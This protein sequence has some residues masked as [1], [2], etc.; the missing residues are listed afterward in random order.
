[1]SSSNNQQDEFVKFLIAAQRGDNAAQSKLDEF[2]KKNPRGYLQFLAKI[3]AD[4]TK[5]DTARFTA[6]ISWKNLFDIKDSSELREKR[7]KQWLSL[8][9]DFRQALKTCALRGLGSPSK[10]V[11]RAAAQVIGKVA[12]IELPAQQWPELVRGLLSQVKAAD[13]PAHLKIASLNCIEYICEGIP[14]LEPSSLNDILNALTQGMKKEIGNF[15]INFAAASA[16]DKCLELLDEP[17][18]REKD[19]NYIMKVVCDAVAID[20]QSVNEQALRI[21]GRMALL[22][23]QHFPRYIAH[24]MKITKAILPNAS[25]TVAQQALEFWCTIC[26]VEYD[27][28]CAIDAGSDDTCHNFIKSCSGDL[29]ALTLPLLVQEEFSDSDDFDLPAA[30]VLLL[31][32]ISATV[33]DA[34]IDPVWAWVKSHLRDGSPFNR[35]AASAAFGAITEGP[36]TDALA[37]PINQILPMFV[38]MLE[39]DSS[40][41]V[42]ETVAWALARVCEFHPFVVCDSNDKLGKILFS[43]CKGLNDTPEVATFCCSAIHNIAIANQD[44][45]KSSSCLD[46]YF[47]NVI[48]SLL[49][50][51]ERKNLEGTDLINSAY[52]AISLLIQNSSDETLPAV[53]ILCENFLTRLAKSFSINVVSKSD[54]EL[55]TQLQGHICAVILC[56]IQKLDSDIKP[57]ARTMMNHFLQIFK[58]SG[59]SPYVHEDALMAVGS[60]ANSLQQDFLPFVEEVTPF[61]CKGLGAIQHYAVCIASV[62]AVSDI[63][64]AIGPHFSRLPYPKIMT[65]LVNAIK[66]TSLHRS[67]KPHILAAFGDIA[68]ALSDKFQKFFPTVVNIL[69]WASKS[70]RKDDDE[71]YNAYIDALREGIL[72]GFTGI[73]HGLK[74]CHQAE[75]F[76][77]F[78]PELAAFLVSSWEDPEHSPSIE[79]SI[80]G[81]IGDVAS[82]MGRSSAQYIKTS[83]IHAIINKAKRSDD[84]SLREM[85][86]WAQQQIAE[87]N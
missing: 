25:P 66:N 38:Q 27:L 30:A 37:G 44:S 73:L 7:A 47:K 3:L 64:R 48:S 54:A 13:K 79:L 26:E 57:F 67:V 40:D 21:L 61:I 86:Q 18:G 56:I 8:P 80:L 65:A 28:L 5:P 1:M 77:Q 45:G 68:N 85:A 2:Q 52:A 32:L 51:T 84:E 36:D 53:K 78:T 39:K 70:K 22:Y 14:S 34:A 33:A 62:G 31:S 9:A 63:A 59:G 71:D 35:E 29:I 41:N 60:L 12:Q 82:T 6:G 24:I 74:S 23:Y 20:R 4:D 46:P 69:F 43:L 72:D 17:M 10:D 49:R 76:K 58:A 19:R 50:A 75:S 55:K 15:E 11:Y 83:Q 81:V 87:M 42:R 16:F